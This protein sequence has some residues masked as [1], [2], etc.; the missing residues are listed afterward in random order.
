MDQRGNISGLK[1]A[2]IVIADRH[3]IRADDAIVPG[4]MLTFIKFR[5]PALLGDDADLA[6]FFDRI[7]FFERHAAQLVEFQKI[8][9]LNDN[10]CC[11]ITGLGTGSHTKP[12]RQRITVSIGDLPVRCSVFALL[13]AECLAEDIALDQAGCAGGLIRGFKEQPRAPRREDQFLE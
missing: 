1:V 4:H 7:I 6:D 2:V 9:F 12:G 13:F 11:R 8:R 10:A 3:R 5:G